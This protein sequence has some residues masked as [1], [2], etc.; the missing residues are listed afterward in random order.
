MATPLPPG[1]RFVDP[2][3]IA[4]GGNEPN[5]ESEAPS[6]PKG[7]RF[8]D[9]AEL[10]AYLPTDETTAPPQSTRDPIAD[11]SSIAD[12]MANPNYKPSFAEWKR[13]RESE[14]VIPEN[15]DSLSERFSGIIGE[16]LGYVKNLA[17]ATAGEIG[18]T[19]IN[20][21]QGDWAGAAENLETLLTSYTEAMLRGTMDL[22]IMSRSIHEAYGRGKTK[23]PAIQG[24]LGADSLTK[25]DPAELE[26]LKEKKLRTQYDLEMVNRQVQAIR[27]AARSGDTN[28]LE[29]L[30]G[31]APIDSINNDIGEG[32][33]YFLD[34]P[35]LVSGGAAMAPK[36]LNRAASR[37][38][39]EG[40]EATLKGTTR[41][42]AV[43]EELLEEARQR[44]L[45][46]AL[47]AGAAS[48][49]MPDVAAAAATSAA[50]VKTLHEVAEAAAGVASGLKKQ[51]S[52]VGIFE[53]FAGDAANELWK[54]RIAQGLTNLGAD[55]LAR[56]VGTLAAGAGLG[57]GVGAA[58]GGLAGGLEGMVEGLAEGIVTGGASASAIGAGRGLTGVSRK[59]MED[60]DINSLR[61]AIAADPLAP[62]AKFDKLDRATQL[63]MATVAAANP[64]VQIRFVPEET[65]KAQ[66]LSDQQHGQ[67]FYDPRSKSIWVNADSP[68]LKQDFMHEVGEA[69]W[70][71]PAIN[72]ADMAQEFERLYGRQ[73]LRELGR[74]LIR[75]DTKHGVTGKMLSDE[76]VEA[77]LDQ[78]LLAEPEFILREVFAETFM[79]LT[80][81]QAFSKV[82]RGR[83][84]GNTLDRYSF[85]SPLLRAGIKAKADILSRLGFDVSDT[86]DL[87]LTERDTQFGDVRLKNDF[88]LRKAVRKYMADVKNYYGDE[89]KALKRHSGGSRVALQDLAKAPY[90]GWVA[91]AD[92]SFE[93]DFAVLKNGIV[94]AKDGA[95]I[96]AALK[97][98]QAD[99]SSV[100]GQ[101]ITGDPRTRLGDGQQVID[102]AGPLKDPS[103]P[104]LGLRLDSSGK[105]V[106]I[107]GSVLPEQIFNLS[108]LSVEA[109][110]NL[111]DL[112]VAINTGDV[113]SGWYQAIGTSRGK[114][115][116]WRRSTQKNL[117]DLRVSQKQF[118]PF[119]FSLSKEGNLSTTVLD[120]GAA[121]EKMRRWK[122]N[123]KLND[124]WGGNLRAFREDLFQYLDNHGH[125][126]P[127]D[128]SIGAAKRDQINA[129]FG[130]ASNNTPNKMFTETMN[131]GEPG[132]GG[133]IRS[134][135]IDRLHSIRSTPAKNWH[136][137]YEKQ[138][139]NL[140]RKPEKES[141]NTQRGKTTL[142]TYAKFKKTVLD[143]DSKRAVSV[144]D[145][146]AGQGHG[147]AGMRGAAVT[148]DGTDLSIFGKP[149]K[150]RRTI[151]TMEPFP[152]G[153]KGTNPSN[154][155]DGKRPDF[156]THE[157]VTG[158]FDYVS[159][160][161][162][163]N[164]LREP[165]R[166]QLYSTAGRSL[167]MGGEAHLTARSD[168]S[169]TNKKPGAK[170]G[171][172]VKQQDGSWAFQIGL[173]ADQM[174][175]EAKEVLGGTD[176]SFEKGKDL[177]GSY[178]VIKR[179]RANASYAPPTKPT[180]TAKKA[181]A[182][183]PGATVTRISK[184]K[185]WDGQART[186]DT[187]APRFKSPIQES[188][189][190]FDVFIAGKPKDSRSRVYTKPNIERGLASLDNALKKVAR[191]PVRM[192]SPTGYL[193]FMADAGIGGNV[194]APPS[195]LSLILKN[196]AA[197][198][199]L[200]TGGYHGSRTAPGTRQ[201]ALEG[202]DSTLKMRE[203]IGD[204]PP[205]FV[206][207]LHHLWGVLSRRL[208]PVDQEGLWLRLVNHKPILD[209]IQSSIDGNYTLSSKEWSSLV[210]AARAASESSA[211]KLGNGGTSNANAMHN[212]L[213]RLNGDWEK[214]ADI[215]SADKSSGDSGRAYWKLVTDVGALEI[216][217]KVQRFVGLTFG[218]P[219][220]IMDRWK[221]VE[222]HLPTLMKR[223]RV[224]QPGDL[225]QYS[226][227]NVPSDP[228]GIYGTFGDID[229]A[230]S[231]FSTAF[232]EGTEMALEQAIANSPELQQLL[233]A[234]ANV[235]GLHWMGWNAIKNEAV[236][237]SSLN[238]TH[239]LVKSLGRDNIT[240]DTIH[241]HIQN[242]T[243]YTE[244]NQ[245][246]QRRR[247]TI[248]RGRVYSE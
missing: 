217:N 137:D 229:N 4:G 168:I 81:D 192:A 180:L 121:F 240:A 57:G 96:D 46:S 61:A 125:G 207:A 171:W 53:R 194:L 13:Y 202:L 49:K 139:M 92:G 30:S 89:A 94:T 19:T 87:R 142:P 56:P 86:G 83:G 227:Q 77:L 128:S 141:A 11:V 110:S 18:E 235:G 213:R 64:E 152:Y 182:K 107:S 160:F 163:L 75:K 148:N 151:K 29:F 22:G 157:E 154:W 238:L 68:N 203:V 40:A 196:P 225:F 59:A 185:T 153:S 183:R 8:I 20:A 62:S 130:A 48:A 170:E 243:Y 17:R 76:S 90:A 1:L 102:L 248:D 224:N 41:A 31:N 43:A 162:V 197:Y 119:A 210:S 88:R 99:L 222:M 204:A 237:H 63:Q 135:R 228:S 247:L 78:K 166:K 111:R 239:D 144:L 26:Q 12:K 161:S 241:Q 215:Y 159:S 218:T 211:G 79:D 173:S 58:F 216:K 188:A 7:L 55:R 5:E 132:G 179:T 126:L 114:E 51:P 212:P 167:K 25:I 181:T 134:L 9:P 10:S 35:S 101:T 27:E 190:G 100:I 45:I 208:A 85:E 52:D 176:Y 158:Q 15:G 136:F 127:G 165:L 232:Y 33:S 108:S 174:I 103:D 246:N 123:G 209:A 80:V 28:L 14:D 206:A 242:G 112:Q 2:S 124:L 38:L 198:V 187:G 230:A 97:K 113:F 155:Q 220:L 178:I 60:N 164:V 122:N 195:M 54:R 177:S 73:G 93:N 67:A 175:A 91:R 82:R 145:L 117:G 34:F 32:G 42:G 143:K 221:F 21:S 71:S 118:K 50:T 66:L 115:L 116:S 16:T 120:V 149:G 223:Y 200:V 169:A 44:P 74:E 172:M 131:T 106:F 219:G 84:F 98:R 233:G 133:L 69:L 226:E 184:V 109:R 39:Q 231:A 6:L 65:L 140:R 205:P 146:G 189:T 104:A 193:E 214:Y 147:S 186:S 245:G 95:E 3:E 129:F 236:G 37:V 24:F 138:R 234:H 191:D 199:D 47:S 105:R 36:L 201:S 23:K 70:A 72:K 156:L 150:N 244:G